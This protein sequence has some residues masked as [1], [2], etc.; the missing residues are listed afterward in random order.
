[1]PSEIKNVPDWAV[2]A[3]KRLTQK[4]TPIY[5]EVVLSRARI[6]AAHASADL[7]ALAERIVPPL[8]TSWYWEQEARDSEVHRVRTLLADSIRHEPQA[9]PVAEVVEV[10]KE[11]QLY[12]QHALDEVNE[13]I[14]PG[15][16]CGIP[17]SGCD[18]DCMERASISKHYGA[19][20]TLL[21]RLEGGNHV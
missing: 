21:A 18:C 7:D 1:M 2:E 6:I 13:R 20:R 12:A 19:I 14:G 11:A 9:V 10:L 15:H 5:D 4:G 16:S 3:A 17:D 8:K